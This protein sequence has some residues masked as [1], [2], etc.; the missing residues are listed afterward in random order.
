MIIIVDGLR[1]ARLSVRAPPE[2]CGFMCVCVCAPV[3]VVCVPTCDWF[4]SYF[5]PE[6]GDNWGARSLL[7][8]LSSRQGNWGT[9]IDVNFASLPAASSFCRGFHLMEEYTLW[10]PGRVVDGHWVH[11]LEHSREETEP[12]LQNSQRGGMVLCA[13]AH[14]N[15]ENILSF[16]FFFYCF[17]R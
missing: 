12:R 13:I 15:C 1:L 17:L 11:L 14:G 6:N 5:S 8:P 4:T 16:F 10:W 7:C 2:V 9:A 3:C